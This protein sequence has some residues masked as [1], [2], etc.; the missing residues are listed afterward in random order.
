MKKNYLLVIVNGFMLVGGSL[1]KRVLYLYDVV[2]MLIKCCLSI[3][4]ILIL[5]VFVIFFNKKK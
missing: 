4:V 2:L 5:I 1:I 3:F